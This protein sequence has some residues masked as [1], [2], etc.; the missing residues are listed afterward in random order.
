MGEGERKRVRR[1]QV[2]RARGRE[3][4]RLMRECEWEMWVG[5]ERMSRERVSERGGSV[6]RE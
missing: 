5:S 3:R 1:I 4:E 2:G 6:E